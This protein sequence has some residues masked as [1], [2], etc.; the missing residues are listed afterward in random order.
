MIETE[1]R[2]RLSSGSLVVLKLKREKSPTSISVESDR[3]SVESDRQRP[4]MDEI[5]AAMPRLT[6]DFLVC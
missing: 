4:F 2:G 5:R 6:S 1:Q 3:I